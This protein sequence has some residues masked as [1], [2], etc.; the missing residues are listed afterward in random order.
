MQKQPWGIYVHVPYCEK[1]CP[2][3]DFNV[4]RRK[5]PPWT[6][7]FA[8]LANELQARLQSSFATMPPPLSLYFWGGTPAVAP[9]A[10]GAAFM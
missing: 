3:C 10:L 9:P 4:Q 5:Q 6:A 1:I 2:Y 7:F 8:A